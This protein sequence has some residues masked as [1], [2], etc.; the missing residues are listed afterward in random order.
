MLS[1][2]GVQL[3]DAGRALHQTAIAMFASWAGFEETVKAETA[4]EGVV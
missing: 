3:T 4:H 1:G 2:R